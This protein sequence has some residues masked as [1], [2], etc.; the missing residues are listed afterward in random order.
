M[1]RAELIG[2]LGFGRP[3][4][5]AVASLLLTGCAASLTGCGGSSG[6]GQ[7]GAGFTQ[8]NAGDQNVAAFASTDAVSAN[9]P[10]DVISVATKF[11]SAATP[12]NSAY[13][14]GPLDVLDISVFKVAELSKVVQVAE[15]GAIN[16]PLVG[17]VQAGGRT[18]QQIERDL[19]KMLAAKY[20][21]SPH[22]SVFVKEYNSQR[23]TVE[24][25]IKKSGV[26]TLKG[27]TTL[28]QILA[29]AEDV[30]T[31][32]ASGEIVIF[33]NIEG[34]R[35]AARFDVDAIKSGRSE[36]P[37]IEA[38]D[39]VVVDTSATKVA[40]QNVLKALPLATS[41]AMFVPLL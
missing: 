12:G 30:D 23:V 19:T 6:S 9:V 7:L 20:L 32:V 24:G 29:I 37:E 8:V 11:T 21:R 41:A 1:G 36:D 17:D 13:K 26:F 2:N 38:G 22:V 4:R 14:V 3:I 5:I 27:R 18:A 39:V 28:I 40:L 35:S 33:R 25:S 15:D 10:K 16:F 34:K 31:S